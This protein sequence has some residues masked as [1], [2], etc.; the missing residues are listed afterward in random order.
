MGFSINAEQHD[1]QGGLG[2]VNNTGT[3][4]WTGELMIALMQLPMALQKCNID[5]DTQNMLMEAI[6]TV[7]QLRVNMSFPGSQHFKVKEITDRMAKAVEAWT[8]WNFKRFGI[9]LGVLLREFVLMALPRKYTV[10]DKGRL[11]RQLYSSSTKIGQNL[12]PNFPI[13]IFACATCALMAG[14]AATR[15]LRSKLARTFARVPLSEQADVE[16]ASE[17]FIETEQ[18]E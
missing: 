17:T 1:L 4:K 9:E 12:N 6:Q 3:P 5:E 10:D 8:N 2:G 11:R 15:P 16:L 13:Y 7:G 18:V 14:F